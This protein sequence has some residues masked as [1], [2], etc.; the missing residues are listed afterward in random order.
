MIA[1]G[2]IEWQRG[3]FRLA[4]FDEID[5]LVRILT[6]WYHLDMQLAVGLIP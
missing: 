6:Q 3:L 2:A 4:N 1:R 5:F